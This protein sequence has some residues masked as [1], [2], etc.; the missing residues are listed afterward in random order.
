M[1]LF[2]LGLMGLVACGPADSGSHSSDVAENPA[3][4]LPIVLLHAFHATTENSWSM[5]NVADA[6]RARGHFVHLAKLPPY[7]GTPERA[8]AA[9]AEIEAARERFCE[10]RG[11]GDLGACVESTKVHLV[12]H[13]QGGLDARYAVSHHDRGRFVAT[14]TTI[15]APHQG[16]PIGDVGLS[17]LGDARAETEVSALLELALHN[18]LS[19]LLIDAVTPDGLA[20]AF[21]WLSQARYQESPDIMPDVPGVRYMSWAGV[22]TSDGELPDVSVCDDLGRFPSGRAGEFRG[23]LDAERFG[24]VKNVFDDSTRPNDGHIPVV[25]AKYGEFLGCVPADHLDLIGRPDGQV[26]GNAREAGFDYRI[27]YQELGDRLV[28]VENQLASD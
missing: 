17:L 24:I 3:A 19:K 13:S 25:S 5:Q 22:A 7:A 23:V 10:E 4:R 27:F 12:G 26:E 14:V 8:L 28:E 18:M 2:A 6:L 15:G 9:Q 1:R 21:Y 16:T 11:A 20:D